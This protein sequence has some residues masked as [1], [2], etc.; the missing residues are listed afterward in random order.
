MNNGAIVLNICILWLLFYADVNTIKGE[1]FY[2]PYA[3]LKGEKKSNLICC[4]CD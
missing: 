1:V 4:E 3:N 2:F